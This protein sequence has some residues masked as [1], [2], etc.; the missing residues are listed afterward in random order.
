MSVSTHSS[1]VSVLSVVHLR[2]VSI[3]KLTIPLYGSELPV[4]KDP[5]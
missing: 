1:E 4:N 2:Q 3:L 5:Y